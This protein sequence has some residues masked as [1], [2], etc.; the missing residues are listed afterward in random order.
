MNNL[1]C[2]NYSSVRT[3]TRFTVLN[4]GKGLLFAFFLNY[5]TTLTFLCKIVKTVSAPV[6]GLGSIQVKII[7]LQKI[8]FKSL[9][10]EKN[11][12]VQSTVCYSVD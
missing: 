12:M 10:F 7:R 11:A 1:W 8:Y 9:P 6:T 3:N 5:E 2:T 4:I